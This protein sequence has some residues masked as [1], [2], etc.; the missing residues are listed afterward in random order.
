MED[1]VGAHTPHRRRVHRNKTLGERITKILAMPHLKRRE[2]NQRLAIIGVIL[3]LGVYLVVLRP[4][5]H[6]LFQDNTPKKAT[7]MPVV[8]QDSQKKIK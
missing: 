3:L 7:V 2:R 5:F 4:L 1:P 8:K 6:I